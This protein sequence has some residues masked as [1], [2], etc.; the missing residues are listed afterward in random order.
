MKN[1]LLCMILLAMTMA[2]PLAAQ[3]AGA[4]YD[5]ARKAETRGDFPG[6]LRLYERVTAMKAGATSANA[7]YKMAVLNDERLND[8]G[9]AYRLYAEYVK[10]YDDRNTRRAETRMK[11]LESYRDVNPVK[12]GEYMSILNSYRR[13]NRK[14][15]TERLKAFIDANPGL[16]FM[17]DALLWLANEYRGFNRRLVSPAEF[18]ELEK[19]VSLW[20]TI[21][22]RYP[23]P[24]RPAR[25]AALKNLGDAYLMKDDHAAA[26]RYYSLVIEEGGEQGRMLVGEHWMKMKMEV[27]RARILYAA[28]IILSLCIG[29]LALIL[30]FRMFG[31]NGLKRGLFHSLFFMP[32]PVFLTITTAVFT[33]PGK[34]NIT[35]REQF[36]M[37]TLCF[38]IFAAVLFNGLV[39]EAEER[40]KIRFRAYAALMGVILLCATYISF[41][42]FGMLK[43]IERLII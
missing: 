33:V 27:I 9:R 43:H 4:L 24:G 39:M 16:S 28:V 37:L 17:D 20:R 2:L 10:K 3:D 38:I 35:G 22:E 26:R 40:V 30:P 42:A 18:E 5:A 34:S 14:E 15:V 12:Y 36:L 23:A 21:V 7:L 19:A 6:A 31:L 13:S 8:P 41:Y 32:L 1:T 25:L 11:Q 29:A